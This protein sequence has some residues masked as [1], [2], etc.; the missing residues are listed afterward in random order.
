MILLAFLLL[1]GGMAQAQRFVLNDTHR[2]WWRALPQEWKTI[3]VEEI[4]V[5][6]TN[7]DVANL[8]D[9]YLEQVM[10]LDRLDCS[11]NDQIKT[12]KPLEQL[13]F[14]E[15]LDVSRCPGVGS[16]EG[17]QNL[18]ALNKLTCTENYNLRD[19]E[20][21][22][23]LGGIQ[24]LNVS[25]TDILDLS[26]LST[27]PN[28][29]KL[30]ISFTLVRRF[31]PMGQALARLE[32]L[33][34]SGCKIYDLEGLKAAKELQVLVADNSSVESI[35]PLGFLPKL[36]ELNVANTR[37]NTIKPLQNVKSLEV[38]DISGNTNVSMIN[39]LYYHD[40]LLR[41]NVANTSV[42]A[43]E[44]QKLRTDRPNCT[45]ITTQ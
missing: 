27:L 6:G 8:P 32:Y 35:E 43:Q 2:A 1:S 15:Q 29:K 11:G 30:N 24:E 5:R 17:I 25:D 3:F 22:R 26:P 41:L 19:L 13:G 7:L 4:G 42:P 12:L 10:L 14:L 21:L 37:I 45:V 33:F 34:M 16:L 28:L 20:P 39:Y 36:R 31:E 23:G 9:Q 38:V 18:R 40:N 44:V